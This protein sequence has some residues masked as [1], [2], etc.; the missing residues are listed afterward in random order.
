MQSNFGFD[1]DPMTESEG[2][3]TQMLLVGSKSADVPTHT[4]LN[5]SAV[6][7]D[8]EGQ[9]EQSPETVF[10]YL[11]ARHAQLVVP[12]LHAQLLTPVEDVTICFEGSLQRQKVPNGLV[13]SE[14]QV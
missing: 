10:R 6:L 12:S 14:G 8:P 5:P 2:Q 1:A 4:Q 7:I 11:V 3:V 9:V 13:L